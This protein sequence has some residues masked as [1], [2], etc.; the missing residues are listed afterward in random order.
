MRKPPHKAKDIR[1]EQ[2]FGLGSKNAAGQG[3][4]KMSRLKMLR[5][6]VSGFNTHSSYRVLGHI[7]E[8]E[9]RHGF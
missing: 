7:H 9:L 8:H 3:T 2:K 5:P 6:S 4:F 1:T